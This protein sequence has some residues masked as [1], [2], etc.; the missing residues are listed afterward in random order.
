MIMKI[1]RRQRL[2]LKYMENRKLNNIVECI[3]EVIFSKGR[4]VV[5]VVLPFIMIPLVFAGPVGAQEVCDTCGSS[6]KVAKG[7]VRKEAASIEDLKERLGQLSFDVSRD[8]TE[9]EFVERFSERLVIEAT[10]HFFSNDKNHDGKL[11]SAEIGL[12]KGQIHKMFGEKAKDEITIGDAKAF[13]NKMSRVMAKLYFR[14][15]DKNGNGML[16]ASEIYNQNQTQSK[17]E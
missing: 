12:K 2:F 7:S 15:L 10:L 3:K 9:D 8:I 13:F 17:K 16:S 14:N 1:F 11:T 4:L 6:A 5:F